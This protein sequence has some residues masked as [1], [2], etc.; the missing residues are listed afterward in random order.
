MYVCERKN[1]QHRVNSAIFTLHGY[2]CD[3]IKIF[4]TMVKAINNTNSHLK[5]I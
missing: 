5:A 4:N 1:N 3:K 2:H